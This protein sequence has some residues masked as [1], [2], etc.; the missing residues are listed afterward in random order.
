MTPFSLF[1]LDEYIGDGMQEHPFSHHYFCRDCGSVW[2]R[3]VSYHPHA[4]HDTLHVFCPEHD[5]HEWGDAILTQDIRFRKTLWPKAAYVR[6]FLYLMTRNEA[7]IIPHNLP[8]FT[9]DYSLST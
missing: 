2:A 3:A 9:H 5:T 6:D 1:L 4:M 8:G 7:R